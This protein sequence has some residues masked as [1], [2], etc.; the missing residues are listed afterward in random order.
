MKMLVLLPSLLVMTT[1]HYCN[2]QMLKMEN[3]NKVLRILVNNPSMARKVAMGD[4]TTGI[5]SHAVK[6]Q[7]DDCTV[8]TVSRMNVMFALFHSFTRV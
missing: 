1:V 3:L 8:C 6:Q 4:P 5:D 7:Q 2:G